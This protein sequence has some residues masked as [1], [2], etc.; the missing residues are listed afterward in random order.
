MV[1]SND[2]QF[3]LL[4]RPTVNVLP[5]SKYTNVCGNPELKGLKALEAI[6]TWHNHVT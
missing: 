6:L 4:R 3:Q 5:V 1:S 2:S